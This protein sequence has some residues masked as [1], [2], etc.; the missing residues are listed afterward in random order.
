[1]E[2][3]DQINKLTFA[4]TFLPIFISQLE[5]SNEE[6]EIFLSNNISLYLC[7]LETKGLL[8]EEYFHIINQFVNVRVYIYIYM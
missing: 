8:K 1:M 7:K 2:I 3:I 5:K 4:E 6:S